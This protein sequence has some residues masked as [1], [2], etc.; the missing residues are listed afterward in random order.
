MHGYLLDPKSPL[1]FRTGR[2]FGSTGGADG[3]A[4]PL[5]SSVAGALRTAYAEANPQGVAIDYSARQAEL[6]NVKV[7]G[8]LAVRRPL[9]GQPLEAL[10]PRPADALYLLSAEGNAGVYPLLPGEG[11][12]GAGCDLDGLQPVLLATDAPEGK[13]QEGPAFWFKEVMDR[14]LQD[15]TLQDPP[16]RLGVKELPADIRSHAVIDPGTYGPDPGNLFQSAGLDF[17]PRRHEGHRRRGWEDY[18]YALLAQCS[19]ELPYTCRRLGGEGRFAWIEP[20]SFWPTIAEAVAEALIDTQR[21]RL[22]LATPAI[23][24]GGW[25]PGWLD[26]KTLEGSPP[27]VPEVRLKLCAAALD[28]WQAVSGWDLV[29]NQPRAVRRLVPAGAVYWFTVLTGAEH[30]ARLWLQPISDQEQDRRDGF[31]LVLPGVWKIN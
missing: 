30:M 26:A 4:F 1:V 12:A 28:R 25:Q 31:G 23:F 5:P 17:G 7:S 14:W 29:A 2:P 13:P 22:I 3:L 27:G 11:G 21:V 10:F 16:A 6:L 20:T 8:P 15:S 18:D 9:D 19:A 24:A